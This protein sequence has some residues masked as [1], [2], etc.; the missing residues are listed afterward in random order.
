MSRTQVAQPTYSARRHFPSRVRR[1]EKKNSAI[2]HSTPSPVTSNRP[3]KIQVVRSRI[4]DK[5][6]QKGNATAS[7]YQRRKLTGMIHERGPQSSADPLN[8]LSRCRAVST[9]LT[10]WAGDLR[11]P[12]ALVVGPKAAGNPIALVV[13]PKAAG[14]NS[15][16]HSHPKSLIR[17][18]PVVLCLGATNFVAPPGGALR[19]GL[20][21]AGWGALGRCLLARWV[22]LLLLLP[23]LRASDMAPGSRAGVAASRSRGRG[24]KPQAAHKPQIYQILPI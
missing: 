14:E 10:L 3:V 1:V 8:H 7:T 4:L 15:A 11:N 9:A 17:A 21:S 19:P 6:G 18:R 23:P 13:G 24:Y 16:L 5:T 22:R 12:V 2:R 20:V